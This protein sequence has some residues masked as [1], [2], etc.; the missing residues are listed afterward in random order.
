[1]EN[2]VPVRNLTLDSK[3]GSSGTMMFFK[4]SLVKGFEI[5]MYNSCSIG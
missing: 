4:K 5:R 1:M 2:A 3:A